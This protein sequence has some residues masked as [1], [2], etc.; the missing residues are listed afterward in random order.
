[1]P[2]NRKPYPSDVSDEEWAF[3]APYLA[4]VREDAPQRAHHLREVFNA[5]RWI[6][7]AGASWRMMPHDLPPW[8]AVYQQTRRWL[9]AGVFE[10]MVHDLRVLLR[11]ASGRAPNPTA[12]IL[13]SRTLRSSPESGHRAGHDGA[14]RKKGSK[15][16]AAVDTLGH[17]LALHVTPADEQDRAQVEE[18][19]KAVQEATGES[20]ELAYVDQ[21]YTGEEPAEA[22]KEHG[23]RLEVVKRPE[24]ERGF[25][26]LPR[27]WVVERDFAWAVRFRRLVKDYERLPATVAGLHFVAYACLF[28]H[29]AVALIGLSP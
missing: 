20:V 19:A 25:V 6:V 9:A 26:L 4:L 29:R 24:A 2:K 5:L 23:I 8:E 3:V 16:H 10:A 22:A 12:A 18:L 15:V 13:D 17:L 14:K 28:L 27:R 21:G 7:R 1:M 11:L